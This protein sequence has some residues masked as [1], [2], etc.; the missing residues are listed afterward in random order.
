M[1]LRDDRFP[2]GFHWLSGSDKVRTE[3][4]NLLYANTV[5]IAQTAQELGIAFC[6]ENPSNSLMWK[7]SPFQQ[8]FEMYPNL[9]FVHFHNCA[10][11]GTRDKR[12]VLLRMSTGLT[13]WSNIAI[14]NTSMPRGHRQ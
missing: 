12:L 13:A 9:R 7:T 2:D 6:I 8:L 10:H 3:A 5:C 4:A 11:G 14:N 1:P